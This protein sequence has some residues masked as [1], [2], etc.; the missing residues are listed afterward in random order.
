MDRQ[1]F[2]RF[3]KGGS[4]HYDVVAPGFKYNMMDLQAAIGLHQLPM[5]DGFIEK[6]IGWVQRYREA[7]KGLPLG[8]PEDPPYP[9]THA[10]HLMTVLVKDRD[11]FIEKMKARNIGIGMHYVAAHLFTYYRETFGFKPGDFPH[12]EDVGNSICSLPLIPTM[13]DAEFERVVKA[14]KEILH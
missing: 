9:H 5:L 7:L 3:A 8:L 10:W 6:R 12:A 4:Q 2:N 14:M 1:A 11:G 13:T